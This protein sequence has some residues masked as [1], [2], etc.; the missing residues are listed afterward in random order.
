MPAYYG[1]E[2]GATLKATGFVEAVGCNLAGGLS[3]RAGRD[4][5]LCAG[6]IR[7]LE[8]GQDHFDATRYWDTRSAAAP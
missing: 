2:H 6:T 5:P 4:L 1:L 3:P 7:M 8:P